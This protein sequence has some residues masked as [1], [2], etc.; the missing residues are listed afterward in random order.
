MNQIDV[1]VADG[2]VS[3]NIDKL[4]MGKQKQAKIEWQLK[5]DGYTFPSDGIVI[6]GNDGQFSDFRV[7]GSG[8]TFSCVDAN[9]NSKDYKYDVKVIDRNGTPYELDPTIQNEGP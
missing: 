6:P 2:K 1:T 4:K 3:V 8:R 7:N 9:T 5:T